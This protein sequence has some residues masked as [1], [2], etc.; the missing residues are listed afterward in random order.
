[1]QRTGKCSIGPSFDEKKDNN[2][3]WRTFCTYWFASLWKV[4]WLSLRDFFFYPQQRKSGGI[5]HARNSNLQSH[6]LHRRHNYCQYQRNTPK[7]S[8]FITIRRTFDWFRLF[9]KKRLFVP[10]SFNFARK[11]KY[12]LFS[13]VYIALNFFVAVWSVRNAGKSYS[14]AR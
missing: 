12:F 14:T 1:M 5:Q 10:I 13:N 11:E 2:Y 6:R 8:A 3:L 4:L 9:K 7:L